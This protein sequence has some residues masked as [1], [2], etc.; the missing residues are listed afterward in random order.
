MNI[1][2]TSYPTI[3]EGPHTMPYVGLRPFRENENH[4]FFGRETQVDE[5]AGRLRRSRFLAVL[6]ASGSGKS[7]LVKA[8]LLPALH[9]GHMVT[10]GSH[11]KVAVIRP[12]NAPLERLTQGLAELQRTDPEAEV[13]APEL[14]I[15][16]VLRHSSR[17]LVEVAGNMLLGPH[18]N[19]L[20]VVDQ[21]EELF[22]FPPRSEGNEAALSFVRLLL[23][24]GSQREVP[25]YVI[26]TMRSDF[27]GDCSRFPGLPEMIN[28]GQYLVPSMSR[29]NFRAA[30]T[31]PAA[32]FYRE[33][34]PPLETRLLNDVGDRL[35]QL[36]IL[37]HALM[38]TWNRWRE[39]TGGEGPLLLRHYE[40]VGG[41]ESALDLHAEEIFAELGTARAQ[42]VCELVFR[43]ITT[44]G[45]DN[46]GI[47][48]PTRF[49]DICA[50][51]GADPEAVRFVL[52][53]FRPA[54]RSFVLPYPPVDLTE[55]VVVDISHESFMRVWKRLTR[56]VDEEADSE[57]MF[58]RI[59]EA[60]SLHAEGKAGLWRPPELHLATAWREKE[61]PSEVWAERLGGGFVATEQFIQQSDATYTAEL[62]AKE[63]ERRAKLRRARIFATVLAIAA[64]I[65]IG[66]TIFATQAKREADQQ[67]EIA[68]LREQ[69][70]RTARDE[71]LAAQQTAE[72]STASAIRSRKRATE[73]ATI[74]DAQRRNANSQRI[75]ADR[76]RLLAL[77]AKDSAERAQTRA[78]ANAQEANRQSNIARRNEKVAQEQRQEAVTARTQTER[79]RLLSIARSMAIRSTVQK[80]DL[81]LKGLL[82]YQAWRFHAEN[83]GAD[84]VPD[85]YAALY[86]ARKALSG[87]DFNVVRRLPVSV[88]GLQF[89]AEGRL[90]VTSSGGGRVDAG[91][92][93]GGAQP[94]F[95]GKAPIR[96]TGFV[97]E[98]GILAV[99]TQAGEVYLT[100]PSRGDSGGTLVPLARVPGSI[101][102]LVVLPEAS[103]LGVAGDAGQLFRIPLS[104]GELQKVGQPVGIVHDLAYAAGS[105]AIFLVNDS[106]EVRS[107]APAAMDSG[108]VWYRPE[109]AGPATCIALGPAGRNRAVGTARG[110]ILLFSPDQPDAPITLSGHRQGINELRFS[111][112]G[113]Y[114]ASVS[115]DR[116]A[117]IWN[118]ADPA[119]LPLVLDDHAD[120]VWSV[121]FL[122]D[123]SGVLTG[124]ADGKVRLFPLS[125]ATLAKGF[126]AVLPRDFTP[127]EWRTYAPAVP[128]QSICPK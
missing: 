93:A 66:L 39:D 49:G 113:N 71:A 84:P 76:Q 122:P 67:R 21:F 120:W 33:I 90:L 112:S 38:R 26:L 78:V 119:A 106:G 8:G 125:L 94:V 34:A 114:L 63:R 42:R 57:A 13:M 4:L 28:Q 29:D 68:E 11:W 89:D 53:A 104:G 18:D 118:L 109:I 108:T 20:L 92:V 44:K 79:L 2:K 124:A 73:Q 56:W 65:A 12:G 100:E 40:E 32:V 58:R 23:S 99:A 45:S 59:R 31:A 98:T 54:G 101:H 91:P 61:A 123:E 43:I 102:A 19:L 70:A 17:G 103:A 74:A 72:D 80:E 60:M 95:A 127:V 36:P 47:R 1:P 14:M 52:E 30:I 64:L 110:E 82:A 128:Y 7:S 116:T 25:V 35:D 15:R 115:H 69:E 37:Q 41:M 51:S 75:I 46:R 97:G 111:P 83:G 48:R 9:S 62:D 3:N 50:I 126:C 24:A 5:L 81:T 77:I 27:L 105:G 87:T 6:G 107:L 55:E 10:A 86:A 117:R 121:A 22:R 96:G 88:R 16:T 85:I